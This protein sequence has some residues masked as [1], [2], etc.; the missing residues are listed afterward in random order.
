MGAPEFFAL[1]VCNFVQPFCPFAV[2]LFPATAFTTPYPRWIQPTP[3][4]LGI[5][6]MASAWVLR[7][8]PIRCYEKQKSSSGT[9]S[10][11]SFRQTP[12]AAIS[13]DSGT[14]S[15]GRSRK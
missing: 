10:I 8:G 2:S 4:S 15:P 11:P 12:V 13:L 14:N 9:K 5:D 1:P 3:R 7:S 6:L